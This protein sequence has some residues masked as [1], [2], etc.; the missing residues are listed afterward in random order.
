MSAAANFN[1]LAFT[2]I[3]SIDYYESC[4]QWI[5]V[6]QIIVPIAL[7]ILG[8]TLVVAAHLFDYTLLGG[9]LTILTAFTGLHLYE[10]FKNW[11]N[12]YED[13]KEISQIF[14]TNDEVSTIQNSE[15][16]TLTALYNWAKAKHEKEGISD[17]ESFENKSHQISSSQ[18]T[19][20]EKIQEIQNLFEKAAYTAAWKVQASYYNLILKN[21]SDLRSLEDIC[22][23]QPWSFQKE[24]LYNTIKESCP[25]VTFSQ[26]KK[27]LAVTE[28]LNLS[29]D[30]IQ[31]LMADPMPV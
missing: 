24:I 18:N 7:M 15:D 22:V 1:P 30:K 11:K 26:Q 17:T 20:P 6:A 10:G 12:S 8:T 3:H 14:Y 29:I 27:T 28:L 5:T 23:I 19:A 25:F 21:K 16:R 13:S 4:Q 2:P 31:E 9:G